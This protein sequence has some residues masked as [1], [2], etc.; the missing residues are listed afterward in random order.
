MPTQVLLPPLLFPSMRTPQG[1]AS[2]SRRRFPE[3]ISTDDRGESP[4][5]GMPSNRLSNRVR[6]KIDLSGASGN[7]PAETL[8]CKFSCPCETRG[9]TAKRKQRKRARKNLRRSGGMGKKTLA[10][11]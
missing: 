6:G 5:L 4:C 9:S 7:G 11:D 10:F 3:V 2:F 8:W 1:H